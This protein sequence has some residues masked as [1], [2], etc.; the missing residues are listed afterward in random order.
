MWPS[1]IAVVL[2][3]ILLH[4]A[5]CTTAFQPPTTTQALGVSC[6]QNAATAGSQLGVS[7]WRD[8][9]KL[10]PLHPRVSRPNRARPPLGWSVGDSARWNEARRIGSSTLRSSA[11]NPEPQKHEVGKST[12]KAG[13]TLFRIQPRQ[14]S[15]SCCRLILFYVVLR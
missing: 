14:L 12:V 15:L 2:S 3:T 1:T 13:S 6:R 4:L 8:G 9:A 11:D 5:C 10:S 7:A